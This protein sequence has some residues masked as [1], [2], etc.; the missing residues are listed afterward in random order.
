[1][2]DTTLKVALPQEVTVT[3]RDMDA[4]GAHGAGPAVHTGRRHQRREPTPVSKPL[5][6]N[7]GTPSAGASFEH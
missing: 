3:A 4:S 1:M 2:T 6:G 7:V 5:L